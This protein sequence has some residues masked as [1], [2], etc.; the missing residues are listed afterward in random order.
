MQRKIA[1]K[2]IENSKGFTLLEVLMGITVFMIGMLGVTALNISSLKSNTFSGN[3][4]EAT[5]LASSRLEILMSMDYDDLDGGTDGNGKIQDFDD[6]GIDG[7]D[8]E[9]TDEGPFDGVKNFGLDHD[10]AADADGADENIG[11][12]DI[13][14][15]FWNVAEDEPIDNAKIL[16]VI[17]QWRVKD[18]IRQIDFNVIRL[19]E[20]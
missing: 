8:P 6:D 4:S 12:N 18:D 19:R 7:D 1:T 3:L 17:V 11:K 13:Y 9:D 2:K 10:T 15:V 5:F 14:S 20:L 16:N